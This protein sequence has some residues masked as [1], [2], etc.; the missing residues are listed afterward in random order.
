MSDYARL[1]VYPA[2]HY[3]LIAVTVILYVFVEVRRSPSRDKVAAGC[4]TVLFCL[5]LIDAEKT[6]TGTRSEHPAQQLLD[7][8][9]VY[10]SSPVTNILVV[11]LVVKNVFARVHVRAWAY[12]L[13]C[14]IHAPLSA[15]AIYVAH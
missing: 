7:A 2:A 12:A 3:A 5:S 6:W 13:L 1:I 8:L 4:A 9:V 15:H 10:F 14:I 11:Y